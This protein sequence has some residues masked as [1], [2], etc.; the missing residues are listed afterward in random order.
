MSETSLLADWSKGAL[1]PLRVL[2]D[3]FS[4][5]KHLFCDKK[6]FVLLSWLL[7]DASVKRVEVLSTLTGKLHHLIMSWGS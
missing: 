5:I 4:T 2:S 6:R 1:T 7:H 3:A